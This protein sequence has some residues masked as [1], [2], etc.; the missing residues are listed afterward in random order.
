M[1]LNKYKH[2]RST[3]RGIDQ[4]HNELMILYYQIWKSSGRTQAQWEQTSRKE[5]P[6]PWNSPQA[7]SVSLNPTGQVLGFLHWWSSGCHQVSQCNMPLFISA[8]LLRY[9]CIY[10]CCCQSFRFQFAQNRI[11]TNFRVSIFLKDTFFSYALLAFRGGLKWLSFPID[12]E[13]LL[14]GIRQPGSD[15]Q[16][17]F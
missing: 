5:K 11:A 12:W 3:K 7:P 15:I 13:T 10:F 2:C 16:V 1:S 14:R 9:Y 8:P 6:V 4:L 17:Y